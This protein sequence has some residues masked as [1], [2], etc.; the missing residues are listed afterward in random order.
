MVAW[1]D[2]ATERFVPCE[3]FGCKGTSRNVESLVFIQ[4]CYFYMAMEVL[5][6]GN[7][8]YIEANTKKGD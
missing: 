2:I 5:S 1:W 6:V 8:T 4:F 7:V 3:H